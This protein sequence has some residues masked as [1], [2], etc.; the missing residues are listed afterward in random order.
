MARRFVL[1]RDEHDGVNEP[2]VVAEGILFR[3][4]KVSL[5]WV[6][7]PHSVH[8][9]DTLADLMMVQNKNGITRIQW[10][11]SSD[12]EIRVQSVGRQR[13]QSAQ[14]HLGSILGQTLQRISVPARG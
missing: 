6:S 4:G 11:D 9:Y 5:N 2:G 8:T 12:T 7:H 14:E 10:I 1:I 13:L 3:S